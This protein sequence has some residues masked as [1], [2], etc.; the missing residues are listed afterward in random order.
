MKKPLMKQHS[1]TPDVTSTRKATARM[2]Y[3]RKGH[4]P[5]WLLM[6]PEDDLRV[7]HNR[8]LRLVWYNEESYI[9]EEGFEEEWER[10]NNEYSC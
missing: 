5:E 8:Y 7:T 3:I 2:F 1:T 10:V 9:H 6:C 4:I